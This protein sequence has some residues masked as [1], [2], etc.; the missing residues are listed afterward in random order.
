MIETLR[1]KFP[2]AQQIAD[3][4]I[5]M[6]VVRNFIDPAT[7][8]ALIGLI[9]SDIR[10]ST[11]TDD[12]GDP[13]FR[14][15]ET[16]DLF[17]HQPIVAALDAQIADA[18]GIDMAFAETTQ[19]QRYLEG[20]QFKLH[21]DYFE[22]NSM[23]FDAHCTHFGQR[24]WTAMVYLN[25]PKAGG[26]TRF[27]TIAKTI[28]PETG[29]LV[30]WNNRIASGAPNGATLHQGMKVR[31]GR[32]YVITKWFRERRVQNLADNPSATDVPTS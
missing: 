25:E 18:L 8:A 4:R 15:S 28:E 30:L 2:H 6:F 31:A 14:T 19:G 3:R 32:K 22:P 17:P 21:T 20:Q 10:P 7:C 5:E 1:K 23:T 13:E 29:K 12:N 9:D 11:I 24:T 27:K 26:A 16:C